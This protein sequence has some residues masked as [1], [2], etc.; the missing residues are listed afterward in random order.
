V[1]Y[2]HIIDEFQRVALAHPNIYFTFF[3][4]EVKCSI[5]LLKHEAANCYYLSGKTNEK[6]VPVQEETEIVTIHGFIGKP[7]FAKKKRRTVF[8]C[9]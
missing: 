8:L 4:M 5:C 7:E 1:E 3:I 6:L 2:R 9:Q